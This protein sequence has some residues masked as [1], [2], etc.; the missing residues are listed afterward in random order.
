MSREK[1]VGPRSTTCEGRDPKGS[2]MNESNGSTGTSQLASDPRVR[3]MAEGERMAELFATIHLLG[4][5]NG[6]DYRDVD[7]QE[8]TAASL[9]DEDRWYLER[10]V[11]GDMIALARFALGDRKVVAL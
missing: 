2:A 4:I 9:N 6:R 1:N 5:W 11:S 8:W 7:G 10:P 3:A